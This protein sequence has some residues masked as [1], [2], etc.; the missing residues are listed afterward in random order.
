MD[1]RFCIYV[2]RLRDGRSEHWDLELEPDF[3]EVQEKE[4]RFVSPVCV[5]GEALVTEGQL[6]LRLQLRTEALMPCA[7]C[8]AET[9]VELCPEPLCHVVPVAEIKGAIYNWAECVRAALLVELPQFAECA[10]TCPE[11]AQMAPYM[12]AVGKESEA[13]YQPFAHLELEI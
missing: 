1:E 3:L 8:N 5:K 6:L 9:A 13:H 12:K 11:R 2:D 10:G 7:V 4:L